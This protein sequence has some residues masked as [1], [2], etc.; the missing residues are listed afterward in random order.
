[1]IILDENIFESQRAQLRT[2]RMSACQIGQEV[3]RQ[4]MSDDQII[5]VLRTLRRPTFFTRDADFFAK[6]LCNDRFC[7]VYV[8]VKPL[9]AAEYIRRFLRHPD[10]KT[11]AQRKGCVARVAAT[12]ISV[13]RLHMP[14]IVR[15]RWPE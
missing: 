11:W 10:F 1:M 2:W 15:S 13:W 12:G 14:R 8:D 5:P 9:Q 7:L 3:G 4:G 6:R